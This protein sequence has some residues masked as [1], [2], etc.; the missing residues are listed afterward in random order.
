M[1]AYLATSSI[2]G[3]HLAQYACLAH[4]PPR[5]D[6]VHPVI[7]PLQGPQD[8]VRLVSF[9]NGK[10]LTIFAGRGPP[11]WAVGIHHF[12]KVGGGLGRG[13]RQRGRL[14]LI[15]QLR[16]T[17]LKCQGEYVPAIALRVHARK[18]VRSLPWTRAHAK[19]NITKCLSGGRNA[20]IPWYVTAR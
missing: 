18:I 11:F 6:F 19:R 12:T 20:F 3:G 13:H 8:F 1:A 5:Y 10:S 4:H 15:A 7:P 14:A 17:L 9:E 2:F 16:P